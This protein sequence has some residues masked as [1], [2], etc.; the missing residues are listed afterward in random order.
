MSNNNRRIPRKPVGSPAN[1]PRE[2]FG[3]Q[4]KHKY[5]VSQLARNHDPDEPASFVPSAST[6]PMERSVTY[7]SRPG[8]GVPLQRRNAIRRR[9]TEASEQTQA[10]IK[11]VKWSEE[12]PM[13]KARAPWAKDVDFLPH[14]K[15]KKVTEE[16]LSSISPLGEL[17]QN[18][19]RAFTPRRAATMA[20]K[21][22]RK[23][24]FPRDDELHFST[25]RDPH[26][27]NVP[28][29]RPKLTTSGTFPVHAPSAAN[30]SRPL[31]ERTFDAP[32][33]WV[34]RRP[35]PARAYPVPGF[36]QAARPDDAERVRSV[37]Q[38]PPP[39]GNVSRPSYYFDVG[40]E[41]ST[42]RHRR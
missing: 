6:F 28:S 40:R 14:H 17:I 20:E 33:N 38:R 42:S 13:G 36:R 15:R 32:T 30:F 34:P 5:E 23:S 27:E 11:K 21:P 37:V 8:T 29:S 35:T 31:N 1:P 12:A 18:P 25:P 9:K 22:S 24:W 2:T 7:D 26:L 3:E 16:H 41:R 39:A 19:M 4:M 10:P